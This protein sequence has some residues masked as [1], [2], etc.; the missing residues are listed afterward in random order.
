MRSSDWSADVCSSD[1][2]AFGILEVILDF[3]CRRRK[4][5]TDRDSARADR[6]H[7]GSG[8]LLRNVT[9]A[10]ATVAL[11]TSVKIGRASCRHRVCQSVSISVVAVSLK[12]KTQPII[13]E[14]MTTD[15]RDIN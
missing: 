12:K 11:L 3:L 9:H 13:P 7:V 1:L 15:N 14:T 8:P 10:R 5:Y 2:L 6:C 4:I